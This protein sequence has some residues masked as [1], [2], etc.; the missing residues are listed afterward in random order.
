VTDGAADQGARPPGLADYLRILRRRKWHIVATAALITLLTLAL[1]LSESKVY[2]ASANVLLSRQDI[3]AAVTGTPQDPALSEDPARYAETQASVARSSAVAQLA[4]TG[5]NVPGRTSGDLLSESSVTPNATAD[6]L[7]FSVEDHDPVA[8]AQLVNAYAAAFASYKLGLDT[9]A[10]KRARQQITAQ[11]ATLRAHGQQATAQYRNLLNS[12]Q[13]L[14]TMQLLQSEDTVLGH[15]TAGVQVKPTPSRDAL[16]GLGFGILIGVGLAFAVEALDRRLRSEE[17]IEEEL[18][19]PLLARIPHPPGGPRERT[20]VTMISAPRSAYSEGV[21]RLAT[22]IGF[23]SPDDPV[24]VLMITSAVQREGKSTTT[25]NLAVA[26]A[27]AGNDVVAVDLDLRQPTLASLFN[28]HRL[29]GLTD[30]VVSKADLVDSVVPV[31]LPAVAPAEQ[32]PAGEQGA[33]KGS[34]HVL[35]TGPL[36]VSPGEFVASDALATRVLAPLRRRYDYVLVDSPP[37]CVVGDAGALSPRVD[38]LVV[39]ARLGVVKRPAL[40]DLRRQLDAAPVRT[41]GCVVTG[42]EVPAAYGYSGYFEPAAVS[43]APAANGKRPAPAAQ[44][45]TRA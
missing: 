44:R 38:A 3:A 36:P 28:I 34:L 42:I 13:Q 32:P 43:V 25:A 18:G 29:S 8:S 15:P 10:L 19:L 14:H 6:V 33:L 31:E 5:A 17:E 12:E 37:M 30:V 2:R 1:S 39:V 21:W 16:I 26:L 40:R 20:R 22:S 7:E 9:T 4:I 27:R 23:A 24:K 41:L 45:R 11:L 35:P